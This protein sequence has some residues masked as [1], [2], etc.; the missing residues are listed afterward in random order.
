MQLYFWRMLWE[1]VAKEMTLRKC[2]TFK[3][4]PV[5]RKIRMIYSIHKIQS[6]QKP[7]L[8]CNLNIE[9][10]GNYDLSGSESQDTPPSPPSS[11]PQ[12]KLYLL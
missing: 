3:S 4:L 2:A 1:I 7:R 6:L 5:D 8:Q 12:P 9:I 11:F 10:L